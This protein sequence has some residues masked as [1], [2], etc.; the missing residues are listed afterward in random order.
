MATYAIGSVNGCYDALL[1]LLEKIQFDRENDHLWFTGNLVNTGLDS[2]AVLRFVR[3]LGKNAVSVLGNQELHLLKIAEGLVRPEAGDTLDEILDAPD[4]DELLKWLRCRKLIH[5]DSKL[6]F[7]LVHAGIPAEWSFSQAL[8]FAYEAESAMAQGNYLALLENTGQ[9]QSRWHAKLRG[10]KRLSF[11]INA[12]TQMKYCNETGKLDFKT[13]GATG[14]QSEGLVPWYRLPGRMASHLNIIFSDDADFKDD[15]FPG[16]YPMPV[17][18]K[19]SALKLA[20]T[21]EK[22]SIAVPVP[23]QVA[24]AV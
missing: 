8:T 15:I 9:S 19:L 6:N 13:S 24:C 14:S 20:A 23:S 3:S 22:I 2:L 17:H 5:H 10:W 11:I 4:R 12:C 7:T 18:G 21:P 16:I 1:K